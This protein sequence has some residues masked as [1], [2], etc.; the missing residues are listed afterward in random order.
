M[1]IAVDKHGNGSAGAPA[2]LAEAPPRVAPV[3]FDHEQVVVRRG[4]RSGLPCIVAIHSTVLGPALGGLRIWHYADVADGQRDAMRLAAAMTLKAAA[5]GLDLGGGK[6]VLCAPAEGLEGARRLAALRD[7]GDLVESLEGRY[8]TAEDVGTS[9]RDLVALSERTEHVTGLPAE[10]GGSGDPSPVTAI[11]VQAAMRA[12]AR[13]RF[14]S[15]SLAGRRVAVIGLG[16]VGAALARNL[17]AAGCELLVADI[18]ERKR[19][20][21]SELGATW[22]DPDAALLAECDVLAPCALGGAI[23]RENASKL[24]AEI[25]CGSA[26]NQLTHDG[27]ADELVAQDVLYAPDFI[28]NAGGLINVYREI[29]GYSPEHALELAEGIEQTLG[30]VLSVAARRGVS[31]LAAARKLARH[32]L[33]RAADVQGA[34]A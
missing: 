29:K 14:G 23:T 20:L 5:A 16:H 10:H 2:T 4:P 17:A 15:E 28:A 3:E 1:A 21:A 33:E 11:G 6:G 25:V 27:L 19:A 22:I 31:P 32:R 12:C 34:V 7:F 18:D 30:N 26:N 24:R 8:I 9:P 13:E